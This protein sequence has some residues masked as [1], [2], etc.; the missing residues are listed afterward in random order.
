M[1][2]DATREAHY[3]RYLGCSD[4]I[5]V[6]S[7]DEKP[8]HIDIYRFPPSGE[9]LFWTLVTSGMSDRRQPVP[10][11]APEYVARRAELL[12]YVPEP[13]DWMFS[14]LKGL[15][16]MPFLDS[17]FLH[18]YHTVQNGTPMTSGPSLLTAFL[19]LPPY[20]ADEGLERLEIDGDKVQFM[21]VVPITEAERQFAVGNG[22]RALEEVF[23]DAEYVPLVVDEE[24]ESAVP[25]GR[26]Q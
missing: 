19:L 2:N 24:R 10:A 21:L 26:P 13:K 7:T 11:D 18:W 15:A 23:A 4:S 22:S 6:H 17:T 16:E 25:S 1:S 20:F 9:S 12:M 8:V 5:V 3:Q 14:V